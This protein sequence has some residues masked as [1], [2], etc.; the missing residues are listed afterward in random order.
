[1]IEG[2]IRG[3]LDDQEL[4]KLTA[5]LEKEGELVAVQDREMILLRGYP[6]YSEDPNA[7][8][9]DIRLRNTN[10][11]CEIMVKRKTSEH[12]VARHE[13]SLSL[14]CADLESAKETVKALGYESGLWMHRKK[15][16]Y[17]RNGIEW[18][19]VEA[20]LGL[21]YYE[22][23][24]EVAPGTD[25]E[26]VRLHLEKEAESLGL[27]VLGPDAMRE[28]IYELDEKVNKEISW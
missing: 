14:N 9:V 26:E 22:A 5:L 17:S 24:Q 1:M 7:R 13:A 11:S 8:D 12:N 15:T 10:G 16:V 27:S 28:F 4:A 6:G 23:E 2:E 25:V 3:R 21:T 20:P 18:S 19:L